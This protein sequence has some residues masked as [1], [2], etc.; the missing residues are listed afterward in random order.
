[1]IYAQFTV[2]SALV[3]CKEQNVWMMSSI[4]VLTLSHIGFAIFGQGFCT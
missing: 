1:M 2:L 4:R 3:L